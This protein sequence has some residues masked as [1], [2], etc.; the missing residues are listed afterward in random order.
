M[1][2]KEMLIYMQETKVRIYT[3]FAR[4]TNSQGIYNL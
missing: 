4:D 3:N 1:W 2:W